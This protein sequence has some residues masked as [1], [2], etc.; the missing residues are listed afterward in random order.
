MHLSS[1]LAGFLSCVF[2]VLFFVSEFRVLFLVD[3]LV[4]AAPLYLLCGNTYKLITYNNTYIYY[5]A[6]YSF[7]FNTLN[8][9][10]LSPHIIL[11]FLFEFSVCCFV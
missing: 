7:G 8:N 6:I 11:S 1:F 3:F 2:L 9:S 5:L 10:L 4:S